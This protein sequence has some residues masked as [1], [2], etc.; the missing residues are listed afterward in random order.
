MTMLKKILL[1]AAALLVFQSAANAAVYRWVDEKGNVNFSNQPQPQAAPAVPTSAPAAAPAPPPAETVRTRSF[2]VPLHGNLVLSVPESWDHEIEQP[3]GELP[4]TIELTPRQGDAF[5]VLITPFW[6]RRGE[7]EINNPQG[8]KSLVGERLS[9]M[10]PTAVEKE[11]KIEEF[12]GTQGSGYYFLVTD[13]DPGPTF[14]YAVVASVG[15]G[16][17]LLHVTI[18]SRSRDS[19][20]IRQAIRAL[21]G[22]VQIKG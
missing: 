13:R 4:P 12:Q 16:D 17:F 2:P 21:Q 11:V 5:K 6:S 20:A 10:L 8:A 3:P 9:Q 15:V 1:V 22:A 18:L 14:P 19:E 7:A